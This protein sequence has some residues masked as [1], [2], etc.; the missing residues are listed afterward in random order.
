MPGREA[1][2]PGRESELPGWEEFERR[3]GPPAA[4]GEE[5]LEAGARLEAP[6]MLARREAGIGS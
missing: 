4:A 3:C 5:P 1:E 2:L 6:D